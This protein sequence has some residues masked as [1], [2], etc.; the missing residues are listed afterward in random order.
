MTSYMPRMPQVGE[1]WRLVPRPAYEAIPCP[2]CGHSPYNTGGKRGAI[3]Q[4]KGMPTAMELHGKEVLVVPITSTM[5]GNCGK[6]WIVNSGEI[7]VRYG[8]HEG[9][10]PY[11]WLEPITE[12]QP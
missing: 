3:S 6:D 10:V 12:P 8:K 9:L 2:F 11:T 4:S 5:C 1:R 7:A